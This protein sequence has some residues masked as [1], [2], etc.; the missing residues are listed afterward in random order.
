MNYNDELAEKLKTN[1]I[2]RTYSTKAMSEKLVKLFD[3]KLMFKTFG[4]GFLAM[5]IE[6]ILFSYCCFV[7]S[8]LAKIFFLVSLVTIHYLLKCFENYMFY[9]DK[10]PRESTSL[11]RH[12][13]DMIEWVFEKTPKDNYLYSPFLSAKQQ[14]ITNYAYNIIKFQLRELDNNENIISQNHLISKTTSGITWTD[15]SKMKTCSEIIKEEDWTMLVKFINKE[16]N[17]ELMP[18]DLLTNKTF[19]EHGMQNESLISIDTQWKRFAIAYYK[20]NTF[21]KMDGTIIDVKFMISPSPEPITHKNYFYQNDLY[22]IFLKECEND[23]SMAFILP[24]ENKLLH[25]FGKNFFP[26]QYIPSLWSN[27]CVHYKIPMFSVNKKVDISN[28]FNIS[29][30]QNQTIVFK[31]DEYGFNYEGER[32][33]VEQFKLKMMHAPTPYGFYATRPFRYQVLYKKKIVLVDGIY[34]GD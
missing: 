19:M 11:A 34:S 5:L 1:L 28:I 25:V 32:V 2:E 24:N 27:E 13:N 10:A 9:S 4:C 31:M 18:H 15:Y 8:I 14:Y 12:V 21:T 29:Y 26:D 17:A 3:D 22:K 6:T 16:A 33:K 7:Q 20:T 30:R 23:I